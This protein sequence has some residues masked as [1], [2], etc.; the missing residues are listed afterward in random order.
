MSDLG[1]PF[2]EL[3]VAVP[4]ALLDLLRGVV[5]DAIHGPPTREPRPS[6][7]AALNYEASTRGLCEQFGF[8]AI[9]FHRSEYQRTI[10]VVARLECRHRVQHSICETVLEDAASTTKVLLDVLGELR[11]Q[12]CSL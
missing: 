2:R 1:S 8:Q 7:V 6:L 4:D 3:F 12:R 9:S 5:D 10:E 11:C